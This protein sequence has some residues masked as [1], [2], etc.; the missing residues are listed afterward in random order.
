MTYGTDVQG[1]TNKHEALTAKHPDHLT[2]NSPKKEMSCDN[3]Q[4]MSRVEKNSRR[5]GGGQTDFSSVGV[6]HDDKI[7]LGGRIIQGDPKLSH[8]LPGQN[9]KSS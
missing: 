5:K 7:R 2:G 6:F 9:W 1:H 3:M 4:C 8:P